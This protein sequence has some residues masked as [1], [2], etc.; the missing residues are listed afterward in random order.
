MARQKR[1]RPEN[2]ISST[3][4]YTEA[5][6]PSF[7]I[8]DTFD[9]HTQDLEVPPSAST[10]RKKPKANGSTSAAP[11]NKLTSFWDFFSLTNKKEDKSQTDRIRKRRSR[12]YNKNLFIIH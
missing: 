12:L 10:R 11:S 3:E 2:F 6:R 5:T 1:P 7:D 4:G 9:N 8:S